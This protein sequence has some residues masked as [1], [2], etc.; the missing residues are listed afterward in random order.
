MKKGRLLGGTL[1]VL[2]IYYANANLLQFC[3]IKSYLKI[4][5]QNSITPFFHISMSKSK[6]C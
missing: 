5:S 4:K 2:I 3:P 1:A 6:R